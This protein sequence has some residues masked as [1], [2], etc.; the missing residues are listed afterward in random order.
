MRAMPSPTW[1]TV[2][3]SARSVST[4]YCS[5]RAFRI[6]VIS[7]GLSFTCSPSSSLDQLSAQALE[8]SAH[9]AVEPERPGLEDD[10]AEEAG[11][12][13]TRCL[14]LAPRP[15]LD[16]SDDSLRLLLVE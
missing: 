2:P 16:L 10:S 12:D 4:S 13:A 15:A 9:A 11:I 5:I 7:S 3:T 8:A 14:H 1:R 6:E